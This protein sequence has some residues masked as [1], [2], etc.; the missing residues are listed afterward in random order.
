V[1]MQPKGAPPDSAWVPAFTVPLP[2]TKGP[3][4]TTLWTSA[5]TLPAPRTS[6]PFRL[7]IEEFEIYQT[8]TAG[9]TQTRLVYADVLGL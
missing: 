4:A 9:Q 1:E 3:G 5:I 2:A 6:Q 8:G 7:R